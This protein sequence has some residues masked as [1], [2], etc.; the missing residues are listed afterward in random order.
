MGGHRTVYFMVIHWLPVCLYHLGPVTTL[1]PPNSC[2][3]VGGDRPP[4]P[5]AFPCPTLFSPHQFAHLPPNLSSL[6]LPGC[7]CGPASSRHLLPPAAAAGCHEHLF[8]RGPTPFYTFL[9]SL[10][11]SSRVPPNLFTFPSSPSPQAIVVALLAAS[12]FS[13][14]QQLQ[15]VLRHSQSEALRK[16]VT[17][18]TDAAA[19]AAAYAQ[20]GPLLQGLLAPPVWMHDAPTV[21]EMVRV[22]NMAYCQTISALFLFR[23]E[24]HQMRWFVHTLCT[25]TYSCM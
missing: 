16:L 13:H 20:L 1:I 2:S 25:I 10:S 9:L 21:L 15:A 6:L 24:L 4:A 5:A 18:S 23:V 7:L 19:A 17:S 22:S 11:T 8:V 3:F 12:V 14:L